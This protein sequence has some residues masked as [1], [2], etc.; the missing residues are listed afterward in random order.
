MVWIMAALYFAKCKPLSVSLCLT[1]SQSLSLS[2]SLL[3][4]LLSLSLC[5][6]RSFSI[7]LSLSLSQTLA[8]SLSRSLHPTFHPLL[9]FIFH[10]MD[11]WFNLLKRTLPLFRSHVAW[12]F[13]HICIYAC[14]RI[15][16][17][18]H[19]YMHVPAYIQEHMYRHTKAGTSDDT[20]N[21]VFTIQICFHQ[22]R[23][24]TRIQVLQT[25]HIHKKNVHT[26][27]KKCTCIYIT[28]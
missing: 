22:K 16:T 17:G 20:F 23:L 3:S 27:T 24:C 7:S 25:Q 12:Y 15:H 19:V 18:T 28:T 9:P 4:L 13:V 14:T 21:F 5:P 11:A 6:T 10:I 8:L 2:L 26:Y 1:L